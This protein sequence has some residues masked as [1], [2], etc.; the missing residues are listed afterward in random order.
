MVHLVVGGLMVMSIW[1]WHALH[2]SRR[3]DFAIGWIVYSAIVGIAGVLGTWDA[4]R[5]ISYPRSEIFRQH[6]IGGYVYGWL[7]LMS[8]V[9]AWIPMNYRIYRR[10]GYVLGV[11]LWLT[12]IW[13]ALQ[14]HQVVIT[15]EF[16]NVP[17]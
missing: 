13:T 2:S 11:L 10:I 8:N 4:D 14:G 5:Y 15:D 1:W 7:V 12:L 17:A 6:E 9:W 3:R 16:T